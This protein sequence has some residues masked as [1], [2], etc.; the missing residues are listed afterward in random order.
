M[1]GRV[2]IYHLDEADAAITAHTREL[3]RQARDLLKA[4]HDTFL[5]RKTSEP[6]PREGKH[7]H[8]TVKLT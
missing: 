8:A 2:P 3:I 5:G 4:P 1:S 6:F 7:G